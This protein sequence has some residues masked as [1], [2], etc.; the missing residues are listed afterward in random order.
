MVY[1]N[2]NFTLA[3]NRYGAKT[4][5]YI[6]VL[7]WKWPS[8]IPFRRTEISQNGYVVNH[9]LTFFPNEFETRKKITTYPAPSLTRR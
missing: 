2:V 1:P 8:K 6:I 5:Q 9:P 3:F 4:P 7:I